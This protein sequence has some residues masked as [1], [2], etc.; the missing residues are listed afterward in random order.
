MKKLLLFGSNGGIGSALMSH[1]E[2]QGFEVTGASRSDCDITCEKSVSIY[3]ETLL[4]QAPFDVVFVAT[5]VL[6]SESVSPEKN[7]KQLNQKQMNDVFEI[8]AFAP[9]LL[10]KAC[11]KLLDKNNDAVFA[12]LSA[13]VGSI[14][15]NRLGGWYSYRASKA[16]LNMLLKTASIELSRSHPKLIIAG[17]HPGT[18]NTKLSEKFQSRVAPEKL[19]APEFAA[20]KL[21]EV[22]KNLSAEDS[23]YCFAWD[24]QKIDF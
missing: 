12:A 18:V 3:V 14:S 17:L 22:I 6:S 19:F 20:Q 23:G 15:D 21:Y 24:G 4:G 16:A 8:N 2:Q 13:R 11:L 7:I 9:I 1:F 10:L 5:G